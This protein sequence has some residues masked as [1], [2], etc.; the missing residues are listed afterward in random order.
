MPASLWRFRQR[1]TIRWPDFNCEATG[2]RLWSRP[3]KSL[4][5]REMMKLNKCARSG[6]LALCTVAIVPLVFAQENYLTHAIKIIVP[7]TPGG[8]VD[9]VARLIGERLSKTLGQPVIIRQQAGRE[10]HD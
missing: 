8:G 2:A 6:L 10:R 5:V 3:G 4:G 9:T 1:R 7:Y